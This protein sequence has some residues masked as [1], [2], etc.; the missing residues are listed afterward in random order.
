M[1]IDTLDIAVRALRRNLL[2]TL[3]TMLGIMIGV[4]AVI[5]MVAIGNGAKAQVEDQIASLGQNMILVMSGNATRGGVS[6]GFGGANSLTKEDLAALRKEVPGINAV[7]PEIR[8]SAQVAAGNENISTSIIG[9]NEEFTIIRNWPLK[10]GVDFTEAEVRSASKVALI[11]STTAKTLFGD[12]DPVG[13]IIRIKSAPFTVIGLL[14]SKGTSLMGNDQDDTVIVPYTSVMVRLTGDTKFRAL[15]VQAESAAAMSEVQSQIADL[16]RQR[17]RITAD[18]DDDFIIRT[19]Q[20]ITEMATS[21]SKVMTMLLGAVAGVSLLVGG[22]G[23]MN[24]MLVS[25]TERTREIG[26]RMSI[27]ARGS[28]ILRQFLIEAVTLS[29][30]GGLIG[31]LLG[32]GSAA[33]VSARFGWNT[34]VST[35]SILM[36]FAFSA[37][38]GIFFGFYPARKASRLDPIDALRYE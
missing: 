13:Q 12:A 31:I 32:V 34:V 36:A 5:A 29:L 15:N 20:Q 18:K 35:Q 23:I 14:T 30:G 19:Q 38:I 24:I 21:T 27:G 22:I 4:A 8:T 7:T 26:V 11:G 37:V 10:D 28:D 1:I 16:L 3:L 9:A 33:I 6:M 25:V 17:H 2:R